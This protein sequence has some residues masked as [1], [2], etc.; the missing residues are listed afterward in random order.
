MIN[1]KNL[2]KFYPNERQFNLLRRKG[3]Y[4]CGWVDSIDK[5][6]ETLLPSKDAFYSR[7]KG[8]WITDED[9]KHAK[10]VWDEFEMKIFLKYHK[11]YNKTD[12]LLLVDVFENFR[13]VCLEN[14]GLDATWYYTSPGLSWDAM[15]KM[16]KIELEGPRGDSGG[17]SVP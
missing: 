1:V 10:E 17:R 8:E 5:L 9:Y 2:K 7:L 11:L 6:A 14:Y 15:L 16:T 3:D 13:D 12:V 4:P